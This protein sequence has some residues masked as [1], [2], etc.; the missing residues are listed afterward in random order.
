MNLIAAPAC[1]AAFLVGDAQCDQIQDLLRGSK[2]PVLALGSQTSAL[3]EISAGLRQQ[4]EAGYPTSTLHLIAHGRPGAFR[5]GEQWIDAEALKAH[6]AD[7]ARWGVETIA[8]WSCHVGADA[9]FVALL[10]E[11]TG[12][13][14]LSTGSWLGRRGNAAQTS[15]GG[16]KLTS[17]VA[18][19][20]WPEL[21]TL[22]EICVGQYEDG[23]FGYVDFN[24]NKNR[25][26]SRDW[27]LFGN[28][29]QDEMGIK[30]ILA[31]YYEGKP[32]GWNNPGTGNNIRVELEIQYDNGEWSPYVLRGFLDAQNKI[33][34]TRYYEYFYLSEVYNKE[35]GIVVDNGEI[36]ELN[37]SNDIEYSPDLN[38]NENADGDGN[39]IIS[40][41]VDPGGNGTY[42]PGTGEIQGSNSFYWAKED[43]AVGQRT[44]NGT[45]ITSGNSKNGGLIGGGSSDPITIKD[46]D[47][48]T[49]DSAPTIAVS[50]SGSCINE[51][52][53][54]KQV[55]EFGFDVEF[56]EGGGL[57]NEGVFD[58]GLS[59]DGDGG[60]FSLQQSSFIAYDKNGNQLDGG[61]ELLD[62]ESIQNG[63]TLVG[64][65]QVDADV[66]RIGLGASW[67]KSDGDLTGNES[68]SLSLSPRGLY[69]GNNEKGATATVNDGGLD[70][71]PPSE[72]LPEV[73]F[74]VVGSGS[75]IKEE[76]TGGQIAEFGFD[77]EFNKGDGLER[78]GVFD[79]G[80]SGDGDG[81]TF[82]LQQSSFIAYGKDGNQ[83]DGGVEL[84][85]EESIQNGNTLVGAILVD[86]GVARIG[87][88]ANW[89]KSDGNLTGNESMSLSLSPRGLDGEEVIKG[90]TA[91]LS[92]G[93]TD[94]FDFYITATAACENVETEPLTDASFTFNVTGGKE[95]SPPDSLKGTYTY[96]LTA[97]GERVGS[98]Y[99]GY[100]YRIEAANGNQLD[101]NQVVVDPSGVGG[102]GKGTLAVNADITEFRVVFDVG[103]L[104]L[105][106]QLVGDESV[107]L[108][109]THQETEKV[110]DATA[111][112]KDPALGCDSVNS[113]QASAFTIKAVAACENEDTELLTDASFTFSV[114]GAVEPGSRE[115]DSLKGTY[116]YVL[117]ANGERVGSSYA[118]YSYR[119]E[120]A[121]GQ[122]LDGNQVVVNPSGGGEGTL[123]VNTDITEFR[124]VFDV[125]AVAFGDQLVGDEEL[126]LELT[127]ADT[128]SSA[129]DKAAL[130]DK[131]LACG[132]VNSEVI[133]SF[134]VVA[135]A[136][137]LKEDDDPSAAST[138]DQLFTD[139]SFTFD[140]IADNI[141]PVNRGDESLRGTYEYEIDAAGQQASAEFANYSYRIEDVNGKRIDDK[142]VIVA[143]DGDGR[144]T[145]S[146]NK[147]IGFFRVVFDVETA[148]EGEQLGGDEEVALTLTR[149][150]DSKTDTDKAS[151]A[152]E[153][154]DCDPIQP[155]QP[156][157]IFLKA[158]AAC[159]KDGVLSNSTAEFVFDVTLDPAS[160]SPKELLYSLTPSGLS[161]E[162]YA[163]NVQ[164]SDGVN[165]KDGGTDGVLALDGGVDSFSI[166]ITAT[167]DDVLSGDETLALSLTDVDEV[168][169]ATASLAELD[170]PPASDDLGKTDVALYL[171]MDNSTSML[172]SD[173]STASAGQSNRLESQ[174]RV[175][176]FAY[177]QALEKAGYGFSRKGESGVLSEAEFKDAV[178]NNSSADLAKVLDDFEVIVDPN[179]SGEAQDLTLHLISYG[180]AVDYGSVTITADDPSAGKRA[181]EAIIGLQTPDQIYGNS[182]DGNALWTERGL[183]NP[184]SNDTFWGE[185]R[186]ASNLYSGTEM[187]GALEGLENLLA[188]Q[189]DRAD[190]DPITTY[191]N[192]TT[193]GR[194][195]RRAW[196][197]TRTG[198]G[199]DS[200]T[201]QSVPL[202]GSLGGD[203]ITTSGLVYD[204]AGEANFLN[205][206]EGELQ[207]IEM[208]NRL[209]AT[210]DAIAA[211]QADSS[212]PLQVSVLGMGDGS[213][214]N[215]PAIYSDL[216][217]LRTFNNSGGGWIYDFFTSYALPDFI[218]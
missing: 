38:E 124:V 21:F 103:S 107:T 72:L 143:P 84:L 8:L 198:A 203:L 158:V 209:N 83:L 11:L 193:D 167:A 153:N 192:M 93:G 60:T 82:S 9:D 140:V 147:D 85:D 157:D 44:F 151:L 32:D 109:L 125:G 199:S 5:I 34:G 162:D 16:W 152:D 190:T 69:G 10:E 214:A 150:E 114:K 35:D 7:L 163:I 179:N 119:I 188:A 185:G 195:E 148:N 127:R 19:Q 122:Q 97:N 105:G 161:D 36:G 42:K 1:T 206:N 74:E 6:A 113:E 59:G 116:T 128:N 101:G 202:P 129:T 92:D 58:F 207:W 186:P 211:Q 156:Q 160:A 164:L 180:Y 212:N 197:D 213:D 171:L 144:G 37:L 89:V 79:F 104:A 88:G 23:Y 27:L 110:D 182:I 134:R 78:E 200:L 146:V 67:V 61:V 149:V 14:V 141:D 80:L 173:P 31:R 216:F 154:L 196:W 26:W 51:D 50:G 170:C 73:N 112:L 181:A 126:R 64:A 102:E 33:K 43:F 217:G 40:L 111:S 215:F 108:K 204:N 120:D 56:N 12:A 165:L 175:S 71:C 77:V 46:I 132:P 131:D 28:D 121:N 53:T 45:G 20:Y 194:P 96:E 22:E 137:C 177:Q 130:D 95:G 139:A 76:V 189:L 63:N 90:A 99:A 169:S 136:A 62:E 159:V 30:S 41:F 183:P 15:I 168:V 191:I 17:I 178:I 187:L 208:Q 184:T 75:C 166:T 68:M 25:F 4:R 210:L 81:G 218:G 155:E 106:D 123:V 100:S 91:T 115:P 52:T 118:G 142:A 39:T 94:C 49:I 174:D 135:S 66:A 98:K 54:G 2:T 86:A 65:I 18:E 138:D 205:N 3:A 133:S 201:G 48:I 47:C 176:L 87:L 70:D 13:Q 145:L 117:T 24:T 29:S 172:Q 55:A 57:E